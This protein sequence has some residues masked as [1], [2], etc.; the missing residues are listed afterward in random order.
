MKTLILTVAILVIVLG[1]A[2]TTFGQTVPPQPRV[3]SL[4]VEPGAICSPHLP[5]VSRKSFVATTLCLLQNG[6]R[7]RFI[8]GG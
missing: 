3:A 2:G 6:Y 4:P 7:W 5:L 8:G 1:F